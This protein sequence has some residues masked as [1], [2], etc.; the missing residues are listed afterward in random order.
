M[1][2]SDTTLRR[3]MD[4]LE[5]SKGDSKW[6]E[7]V[8]D[9]HARRQKEKTGLSELLKRFLSAEI[10][11]EEFRGTFDSRTRTEW[12]SFG[13]KGMSGAMVLNMLAKYIPDKD[14]LAM[15]LREV[16][17]LPD[18]VE[19]ARDKMKAFYSF[20]EQV[21]SSGQ[22]TRRQLQP[23]RLPF[24][25]SAWWHM[26]DTE[27]WPI[28]YVSARRIF[29][30]EG[31]YKSI[32]DVVD[33]YLGFRE[34]FLA[35]SAALELNTWKLEHLCY[36][37]DNQPIEDDI[38]RGSNGVEETQPEDSEEELIQDPTHTQ[39]QWLIAKI[40]KKLGCSVWIA[41][42]DHNREWSGERLGDLSLENLP[43]LGLGD[44]SQRIISLIDVLWIQGTNQIV[45]AF[46]VEHTTSVYSGLLRMSDLIV[47]SP[48]V[49]FPIYI[50]AP[51]NRMSK[52]KRELS[53]P[54]FQAL[55]LHKRCGFFSDEILL[56]ESTA[57]LRWAQTPSAI[58]QLAQ[59]VS[60]V[61]Y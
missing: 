42:N 36:W 18:S 15:C 22:A 52:V 33:D 55:E 40:G 45:A 14:A 6:A 28:F 5:Q 50:V 21:I 41:S 20:V 7:E 16:L 17:S 10:Q 4:F 43:F 51:E 8:A 60:D 49:N 44:E 2:I 29:E 61:S 48:N 34:S 24:F 11:T 13:L 27:K 59:R 19:E 23:A 37:L 26:Q 31:L 56:R 1:Q 32:Q 35:L 39:I 25:I 38:G 58:D 54:T 12:V 57:M 9:R 30:R 53:R 46:E 3:W 47:L